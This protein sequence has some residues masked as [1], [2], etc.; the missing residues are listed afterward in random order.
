MIVFD[1]AQ[2]VKA[3]L[4]TSEQECNYI[5]S[6]TK[7]NQKMEEVRR[8]YNQKSQASYERACSVLVNA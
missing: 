5:D 1:D 3:N 8:E 2:E 6:V 7:M 4:K